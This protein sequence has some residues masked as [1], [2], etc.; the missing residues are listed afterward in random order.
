MA[1]KKIGVVMDPI[2]NIKPAKDTTLAMLLEAQARGY[3]LYYMEMS[4]LFLAQGRAGAQVA[5]LQVKDDPRHWYSLGEANDL[6]LDELDVILMRKDPPVDQEFI[7][8]T[9]I[10]EVAERAGTLVINRPQA[11]RDFNEKLALARYSEYTAPTRVDRNMKRLRAFISEH[12]DTIIKPLDG[13]GG[14]SIFRLSAQDPNLGVVLETL[15]DHGRRYAMIQ[16]YLPEIAQGDK[17]I[18]VID[19]KPWPYALARIPSQGETRGNLAAGGRGVGQALSV[20]DRE[21]AEAIGPSLV[22]HG[23]YFVGLDVIGDYLTEV[24]VTSPTCVRELD[25][26]FGSNICADLFAALEAKRA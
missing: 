5:V 22:E 11:L 19:G 24:N 21:I 9:Q 16:K 2:A 6:W 15:T 8:A 3:T 10:L 13:M 12:G 1:I 14:A 18:L 23:L 26:Q 4:D 25:K 17:R 20:R 7:Y